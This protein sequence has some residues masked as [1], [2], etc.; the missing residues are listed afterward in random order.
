MIVKSLPSQPHPI[1]SYLKVGRLLYASLVLFIIESWF[2]WNLYIASYGVLRYMW[3]CCFL[4]SVVHIFLVMMDGWSR[5]QNYKRAKDQFYT[6]GFKKRIARL[7]LVSKC[8][9]IA[10]EVAA[11]ELGLESKIKKYYKSKNI[12]W[13][14]F[15]PS[16]IL[17]DPFFLF[18]DYFWSRT[19]LEK[20]YRA[21][22]NYRSLGKELSI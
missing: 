9:R 10:A 15:I 13:Y 22:Y 2:F 18:R 11:E 7:Y 1:I 6:H 17:K 19:F 14:H 5:Y 4:F 21:R 12:K 16:F 8:Q 20:H 3:F